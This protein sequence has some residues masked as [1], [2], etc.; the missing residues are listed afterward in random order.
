MAEEETPAQRAQKKQDA[1]LL[2]KKETLKRQGTQ[3]EDYSKFLGT[4]I[5]GS[6]GMTVKDFENKWI[7]GFETG[8]VGKT[9]DANDIPYG[10]PYSKRPK[11]RIIDKPPTT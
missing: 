8:Y 2:N 5:P 6:S 7:P 4:K 1:D 9:P 11:V 10:D 3:I